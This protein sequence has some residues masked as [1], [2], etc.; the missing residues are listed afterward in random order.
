[1]SG[2]LRAPPRWDAILSVAL[3][4]FCVAELYADYAFERTSVT[5]PSAFH[6]VV[7]LTVGMSLVWRRVRPL[8]VASFVCSVLMF[9]AAVAIRPNVYGEVIV[10]LIVLYGLTA[11]ASSWRSAATSTAV[12]VVIAVLVGSSDTQDPVGESVTFVI[13]GGVVL[14]S[15]AVVRRHRDKAEEMRDQRDRADAR[16]RE[17]AITERARIARELHDVVA[18]GMSIVVLQARGGRRM[19]D[20]EPMR[21]IRAFDD[22][23]RVASDCLEEMRRL[24]GIL[25]MPERPALLLIPQPRL[26]EL[27]GL[28][29][30][31]QAS[32]ATVD[33]LVEGEQRE[34][35]PAIE[36]S[37]YRIAQEALTN[38]LK[39]APGSAAHVHVEYGPDT[40]GIVV[41]DDGPG[42]E[43]GEG[44]HG[45]IGMRERVELFGGTFRVGTEP[46]GGFGVHARLPIPEAAT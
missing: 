25:R 45:L 31:A 29:A 10:V 19:V 5:R 12:S 15:G 4:A 9:Q 23:D 38:S 37:A 11:Y 17:I 33:L 27:A 1:M 16:A 40:I 34:L 22:I 42:M 14:L 26:R 18:H 28:V 32:G 41:T 43:T 8:L 20:D 2:V 36:L 30:Q 6:L 21:A 24:L 46:G 35:P 3:T 44:G 39:H 13:F 7:A